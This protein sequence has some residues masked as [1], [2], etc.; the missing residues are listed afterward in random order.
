VSSF[1]Y[2]LVPA[3]VG[4]VFNR[5]YTGRTKPIFFAVLAFLAVAFWYQYVGFPVLLAR[6][7]QWGRTFPT[8]I[9]IAVGVASIALVGLA[10][11]K[12][13][14]LEKG[15]AH[16][17]LIERIGA[18]IAALFW[19]ALIWWSMQ[20]AP[21]PV[22]SLMDRRRTVLML[23]CIGWCSYALASRW[24]KAF[25]GSLL[26]LLIF[27]TAAFNPWIIITEPSDLETTAGS[28]M[29]GEGRTLVLGSHIPA[30]TLMASGCKVLNGVSY[31]PQLSLW[32][33]LDPNRQQVD[34]YNRYQHLLVGLADLKGSP[35]PLLVTP[36]T[37]T[38]RVTVDPHGFD[39]ARLPISYVLVRSDA[40][41]TL[42]SNPTL[43]K[44]APFA[45]GWERFKVVR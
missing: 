3:L 26:A 38:V 29:M 11:A 7:T 43:Q 35:L 14:R 44:M 36:Q 31:Y 21:E 32:R 22:A 19:V 37:D 15:E 12:D 24:S 13:P 10:L 30:M 40:A 16:P 8:R 34:V 23:V 6:L 28:C 33:A 5:A 20:H 9:D 18:G 2:F 39:F 45:S 27:S 42:S 25:L 1:L 17:L 4:A 41:M